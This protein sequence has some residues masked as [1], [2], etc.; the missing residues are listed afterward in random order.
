[1]GGIGLNAVVAPQ[2]R[3]GCSFFPDETWCVLCPILGRTTWMVDGDDAY[4]LTIAHVSIE[5]I[6]RRCQED[7][8]HS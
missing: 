2:D 6:C 1:M 5:P 8:V 7:L 4:R 3:I